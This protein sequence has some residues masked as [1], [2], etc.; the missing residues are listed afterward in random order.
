MTGCYHDACGCGYLTSTG[1]LVYLCEQ[2][3]DR[4]PKMVL[5]PDVEQKLF[6]AMLPFIKTY[7]EARNK[8]MKELQCL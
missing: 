2:H 6:D 1:T 7:S 4:W 8:G 5:P 3:S